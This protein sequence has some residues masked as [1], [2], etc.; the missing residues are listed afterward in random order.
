MAKTSVDIPQLKFNKMSSAKYEELKLAGQLVDNEFYITPDGGTIPE[1]NETTNDFVLSNN[2]TD[3][4]WIQE[5][6][7]TKNRIDSKLDANVRTNCITKIP[8]NIKL[9]LKDGTLT[10]KAGSKVYIPNGVGVFD[11]IVIDRDIS[12][13][14]VGTGSGEFQI[15]YTLSSDDLNYATINQTTSGTVSPTNGLFYNTDTNSIDYYSNGVI[16]IAQYSFPLCTVNAT[17]GTITSIDQVFNGFGFIGKKIFILPGTAGI[18]PN[19]INTD[20]TLNNIICTANTVKAYDSAISIDIKT[21]WTFLT[22]L[23]TNYRNSV[24]HYVSTSFIKPTAETTATLYNPNTNMIYRTD[25]QGQTWVRYKTFV[26]CNYT[27]SNTGKVSTLYPKNVFNAV[28]RNDTNWASLAGKPSDKYIDLTLEASGS[29]Y[30][31]PANG[32]FQYRSSAGNTSSWMIMQN[33]ASGIETQ[34]QSLTAGVR[35]I[36]VNIEAKKGDKV[37]INYDIAS[38]SEILFR[39]VYD[40][41]AR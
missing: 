22:D 31:A 7:Y 1:V 15:Y 35:P 10:L 9:E 34:S 3:L 4:N 5:T 38:P 14:T 27:V 13:N 11:E 19:G 21:F 26:L 12:R 37:V 29:S 23:N 2:G 30:K 41:G 6:E 24:T 8:Q 32:R 33:S 18:I 39:F 25:D 28:D 40:E 36:R 16:T 17:S 20:G